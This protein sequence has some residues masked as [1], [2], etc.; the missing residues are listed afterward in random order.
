[1]SLLFL[2]ASCAAPIEPAPETIDANL[3]WFWVHAG[4]ATDAELSTGAAA[5]SEAGSAPTRAQALK[6]RG[7][8]RLTSA[9]LAPIGLQNVDPAPAFPLLMLDTFRCTLDRLAEILSATDQPAL[10]PMVWDRNARTPANDPA[11]FV[12]GQRATLM[13]DAEIGVTF[14]VADP[15]LSHFKGSLRRVHPPSAEVPS[16]VLLSRV[17]L[18]EPAAFSAPNST[19]SLTHDYEVHLFWEREPG[20]VFHAFGLWREVK[21]GGFNLTLADDEFSRLSTDEMADW[22][23]KTQA[24]CAP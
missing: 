10:Y 13:W 17:W 4:E 6:A 3:R 19:S 15:Y 8:V 5:L 18:T 20:V 22:D 24:L 9:D 21:V 7:R 23:L 1:M 11:E 14:P 16:D 2:C 12:S